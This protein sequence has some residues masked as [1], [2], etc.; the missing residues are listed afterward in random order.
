MTCYGRC[1]GSTERLPQYYNPVRRDIGC[2]KSPVYGRDCV[3]NEA[4]LAGKAGTVAIASIVDGK[5]M[6]A[7]WS[8][9]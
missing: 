3:G 2:V 4:G 1:Y 5:D 9:R 7:G 6:D 8:E